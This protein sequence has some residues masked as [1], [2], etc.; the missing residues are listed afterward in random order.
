MKKVIL[1]FSGG[2]DTSFCVLHLQQQGYDVVTVTVDTGGFSKQD[3]SEIAKQA[4]LLKVTKHYFIDGKT[5]LYNALVSYLIKGNILRGGVYPLAVGPE[6]I[7]IATELVE[8]AK[9]E[10]AQFVSHGSTGAGNDQIRFDTTIKALAPHLVI[11]APIRD[12]GI[13]REEELTILKKHGI[14]VPQVAKSYSINKGMLGITIGGKET[15]GSWEA[16]PESV[17][18]GVNPLSKTPDKAYPLI[19]SFKNGLPTAINGK[20]MNGIKIMKILADIGGIHGIGKNIHLGN[21][22]LGLKGRV[23]FAAPAITILIKAHKELEKLVLTRWQSFWKDMM[24]E[25][26]GGFLHEALYFDPIMKDIEAMIDS[27][28]TRVT[29]EVKLK[30]FKGNIIIEGYKSPYSLMNLDVATYGE[31]NILWDGNDAKSFA[32]IYGM[33]SMLAVSAK[34][35]GEKYEK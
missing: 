7:G 29:G 1:A 3:K 30:L 12:L 14:E 27:S 26:Y 32:K 33:Q 2:L 17:Y 20:N 25:V 10:K 31:E 34:R 23:A 5:N 4:K 9:K 24:T 8:L 19:I 22:I 13:K 6:R 35:I 16:P 11:L 28:Q 21:T 18:E 15:K